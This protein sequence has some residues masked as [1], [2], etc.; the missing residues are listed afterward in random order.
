MQVSWL[1]AALAAYPEKFRQRKLEVCFL[2]NN[3]QMNFKNER[4]ILFVV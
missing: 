3:S 4:N 2:Q 1:D